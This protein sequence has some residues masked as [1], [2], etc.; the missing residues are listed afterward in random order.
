MD[1]FIF[2]LI[3]VLVGLP[4]TITYLLTRINQTPALLKIRNSR[5][6]VY[7]AISVIISII[8]A[9]A[10]NIW[11]S[12]EIAFL[13]ILGLQL[14]IYFSLCWTRLTAKPNTPS[15]RIIRPGI[16]L[17]ILI[18]DIIVI[19]TFKLAG[20]ES[21]NIYA[22]DFSQ[23]W[24]SSWM[25]LGVLSIHLFAICG[26][27]ILLFEIRALQRKPINSGELWFKYR[28]FTFA[29]LISFDIVFFV[30]GMT[31][32]IIYTVDHNSG[33][34]RVFLDLNNLI[35]SLETIAL[36]LLAFVERKLFSLYKKYYNWRTEKIL[37]Q[38]EGLFEKAAI[39]LPGVI[40]LNPY[41]FSG[42]QK[43]PS[44]MWRLEA[45]VNGFTDIRI[46]VW[47]IAYLWK[48]NPAPQQAGKISFQQEVSWWV[49]ILNSSEETKK[50][51]VSL[52]GMMFPQD[53]T[54]LEPEVSLES[55]ARFYL[56][57]SRHIESQLNLQS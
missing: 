11:K 22:G 24:K 44:P 36:F 10:S 4:L 33:I 46:L 48:D 1:K 17:G 7:S 15:G 56:K 12:N 14:I 2:F 41:H 8:F 3:I 37:S 27:S 9:V 25:W 47:R 21:R 52:D 39:T 30:L 13:A 57:L 20:E 5:N 19:L 54:P 38:L 31:A 29:G 32:A 35:V 28:C 16:F 55:V 18:S 51:V 43:L 6:V 34:A 49:R 40:Q 50:L 26:F 42:I 53:V 45:V 23:L